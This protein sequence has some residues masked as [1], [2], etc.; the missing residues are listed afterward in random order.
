MVKD[1]VEEKII[2]LQKSKLEVIENTLSEN[3]GNQAGSKSQLTQKDLQFLF[4]I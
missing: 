2:E 3:G 4:G 1:S